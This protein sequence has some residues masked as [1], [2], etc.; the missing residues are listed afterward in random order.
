MNNEITIE[1]PDFGVMYGYG[2][3]VIRKSPL[4]IPFLNIECTL[5]FFVEANQITDEQRGSLLAVV[6]PSFSRRKDFANKIFEEYSSFIR[7]EYLSLVGNDSLSPK[8]EDLP[9]LKSADEVWK[10]IRGMNYL[11]VENDG[12]LIFQFKVIFDEEHCL[13]V[14][15]KEEVGEAWI[16]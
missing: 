8:E 9:E 4:L 3:E 13:N 16:E 15:Y 11:H 7:E 10:L 14:S 6:N 1:D 5:S 12:D 2:G